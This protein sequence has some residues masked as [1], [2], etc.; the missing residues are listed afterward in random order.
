MTQPDHK[1]IGQTICVCCGMDITP[2]SQC[3][4]DTKPYCYA[5]ALDYL[6]KHL[7]KCKCGASPRVAITK[8][9]NITVEC[10]SCAYRYLGPVSHAQP[11]IDGWETHNWTI[12][13]IKFKGTD[14][15]HTYLSNALDD[16]RPGDERFKD[17][18]RL[19]PELMARAAAI[20]EYVPDL[21][22]ATL[23]DMYIC[24]QDA[25][26]LLDR[27]ALCQGQGIEIPD[28][29]LILDAICLVRDFV[30]WEQRLRQEQT[31]DKEL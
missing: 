2:D 28:D 13:D 24:Q 7:R 16:K 31:T 10:I 27:L 8:S 14:W 26:K 1:L 5:C 11:V 20:V 30:R 3:L 19:L 22:G 21:S 25:Y 23:H 18:I 9:G 17:A 6:S 12:D 4:L 15:Y 29:Y